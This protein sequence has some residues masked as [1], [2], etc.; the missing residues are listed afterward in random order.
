MAG[1][2]HLGDLSN[3]EKDEGAL[4]WAGFGGLP[5]YGPI[6]G[7]Q[8][9][10]NNYNIGQCHNNEKKLLTKTN[11]ISAANHSHRPDRDRI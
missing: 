3:A 1:L 7:E 2:V 6:L 4:G 9:S 8:W 5:G 10:H 11:P